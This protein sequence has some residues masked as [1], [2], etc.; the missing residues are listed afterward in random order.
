M[1]TM[2][3]SRFSF[4]SSGFSYSGFA[5]AVATITTKINRELAYEKKWLK[6]IVKELLKCLER[7][8]MST[9]WD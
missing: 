5:E 1:P 4:S 9:T 3:D 8:Y 6:A 7:L 2:V